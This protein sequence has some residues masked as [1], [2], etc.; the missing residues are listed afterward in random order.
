MELRVYFEIAREGKDAHR[1]ALTSDYLLGVIENSY[2]E[3]E[4]IFFDDL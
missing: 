3:I 2:S 4:I 1:I